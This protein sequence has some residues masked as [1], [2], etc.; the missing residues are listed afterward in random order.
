[1]CWA[2]EQSLVF[3]GGSG[4]I[5]R[6][7]AEGAVGPARPR[8]Y[9]VGAYVDIVACL[10]STVVFLLAAPGFSLGVCPAPT[11]C[12]G[13]VLPPGSRTDR[14]PK[15]AQLQRSSPCQG[16]WSR[17]EPVTQLRPIRAHEIRAGRSLAVRGGGVTFPL[18]MS[19][20]QAP[21]GC[22]LFSVCSK[23]LLKYNLHLLKLTHLSI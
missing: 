18:G 8:S 15:P 14:R 13:H 12:Q 3:P 2:L 19:K 21:N 23:I 7:G 6:A 11:L 22:R 16:D 20:K 10:S 4:D 5:S 1:M 9:G 17:E